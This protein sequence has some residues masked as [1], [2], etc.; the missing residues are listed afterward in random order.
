MFEQGAMPRKATCFTH[1]RTEEED[2]VVQ[3]EADSAKDEADEARLTKT[4][5]NFGIKTE[6]IEEPSEEGGASI[7]VRTDKAR[8]NADIAEKSVTTKK[9]VIRRYASRLPLA[10]NSPTTPST[11]TMTIAAECS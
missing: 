4:T 9:N 5:R 2:A 7:P 6:A 11:P 10:D 3:E 8:S 1:T